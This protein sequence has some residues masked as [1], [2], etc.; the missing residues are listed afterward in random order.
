W[1][2]N[3]S[4]PG[5]YGI[6]N[7]SVV[8][9]ITRGRGLTSDICRT[10]L[11]HNHVLWAGTDMGLNAIRLDRP[12]YPVTRYTAEDGL[13]SNMINTLYV[14]STIV[15]A[16]TPAG[17]SL[18][19]ADRVRTGEPCELL[20]LGVINSGRELIEDTAHLSLPYR[21]SNIRFEYAGISYRSAEIRYR[22]RMLGLDSGWRETAE[23]FLDYPS[24]PSGKYEFQVQATNRFGVRSVILAVPF[25]VATPFWKQLWFIGLEV[26]LCISMFWLFLRWRIALV[27][28]QQ[29]QKAVQSRRM[30]ELEHI[31]LQSQM[32][33]HFIFNCLNSI[34]QFVFDKDMMA[35]NEYIS[36]FARLIRATLNNSTRALITVAEEVEYLSNYLSL[37]K[38]RFKNKMHYNI[39]LDPDLDAETNLLPP[40]LLQPYVENS[41]RHG[42]RHK[43]AGQGFIEIRFWREDER[44]I[45]TIRDNGI[46]RKK[47]M[48]YRTN[49]HIEY[50]SKGM[51]LTS[52]RIQM[53]QRLYKCDI[54]VE[55]QDLVDSLGQP[56]GTCIRLSFPTFG[57]EKSAMVLN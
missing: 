4:D 24:L 49:E 26:V 10:L 46:G 11:V 18:F 19:D 8:A 54:R 50:Q 43:T 42:L 44:V 15:Y 30:A 20:L 23:D 33:P 36:G 22:Y 52:N 47:A 56:E 9:V 41:V 27:R 21:Q 13:G 57:G 2:S 34:Q 28:R 35:T 51:T 1:V 25:V 17:V 38:M 16:G 39:V 7:D 32:N 37:E 6:R 45:I 14:D 48:E 3:A 40:M 53:I 5:I 29:E 12:G 31:A 55:V